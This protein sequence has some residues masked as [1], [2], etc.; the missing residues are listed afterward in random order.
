MKLTSTAALASLAVAA[1]AAPSTPETF[2]LV[3]IR[4]GDAVQYAGFNAALGSIFAGLPKQNATCE[5]TDS[6]FATF[7]IKD[8]ALY[9][10]GSDETQEIYVDRSGMG[11]IA[12]P[13]RIAVQY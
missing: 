13:S 3:A 6:G 9:L 11:M 5:G 10:Y 1:T 2:G 8:G 7:Y 12:L 4:S